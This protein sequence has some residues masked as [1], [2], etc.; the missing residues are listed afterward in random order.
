MQRPNGATAP[1]M[2]L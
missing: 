1:R 2:D